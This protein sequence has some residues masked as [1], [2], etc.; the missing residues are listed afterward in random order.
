M[1]TKMQRIGIAGLL[2]AGV[3]L[4]GGGQDAPKTI[5]AR[6]EWTVTTNWSAAYQTRTLMGWTG[7]KDPNVTTYHETGT[8]QSNLVAYVEW[9]GKVSGVVIETLYVG[10]TNRSY[11]LSEPTRV[12]R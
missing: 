5:P 12:Y 3:S 9:K 11:T 6:L 2:F 8:I 7:D 1:K 10:T 4:F